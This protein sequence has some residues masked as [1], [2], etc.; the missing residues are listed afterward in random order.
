MAHADEIAGQLELLK[1]NRRTLHHYLVQRATIGGAFIPPTITHGI[2]EARQNIRHIKR[3]LRDWHTYVEDHPDD[4][5]VCLPSPH[6]SQTEEITSPNPDEFQPAALSFRETQALVGLA[7]DVSGSMA[8]SMQNNSGGQL[9]RLESFRLALERVTKEAK[10]AIRNAQERQLDTS[11]DIFVYGF[12]LR[13]MNVCDLL[14]LIKIGRR[15]ISPQEIEDIKQRYIHE[16]Q[17]KYSRYSGLGDLARGYGFGSL[18]RDIEKTAR[19]NAEEE[20]RRKIMLEVKHRLERKLTDVGDT[21]VPIEEAAH[22]WED[23]GETLTNAEELIYGNTPMKEAIEIIYARIE[24]EKT[25]YPA[26]VTPILFILS[27]GEPT[28]GNPLPFAERIIAGGTV[29]ISCFITDQDIA[30]PRILFGTPQSNWQR[31]AQLMF[32]MASQIPKDSEFTRFLL[33]KGWTIEPEAKLFVQL[34]HS[35]ILQEF[36]SMVLAPFEDIRERRVLPRGF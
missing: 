31:G 33:Q 6:S 9:S 3:T 26:G 18:V 21:T 8:H 25:N 20:I 29:I 4:E 28:D 30:N 36:I 5:D 35:D 17:S 19:T 15:I 13:S 32:Q 11:I 16:A 22:L 10:I 34:N 14:S 24:R 23:S 7:V 27:D 2:D 1:A 12:G